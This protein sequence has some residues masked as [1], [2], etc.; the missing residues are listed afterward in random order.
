MKFAVYTVAEILVRLT[1]LEAVAVIV[2][3]LVHP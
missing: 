2:V 1:P 3:A